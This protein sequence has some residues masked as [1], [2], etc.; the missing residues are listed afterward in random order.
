MKFQF[1][2][3]INDQDYFDYNLFWATRSYYGKKQ[4]RSVRV[5][6]MLLIAV[7]IIHSFLIS[8]FSKETVLGIIPLLILGLLSQIL[9]IKF[10]AFILKLHMKTLK[11][12]GKM[13]YSPES[14]I[15]FDDD[16][17][18]ETTPENKT[19]QKYSV[20]ERISVV[21]YKMIY[22]HVNTVLSYILPLSSFESNDQYDCF[23]EF[24]KT[25]CANIDLY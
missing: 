4:I 10:Y 1:H 19:E 13:G 23:M 15:E 11:K 6:L 20:I 25:K 18:C 14:Y 7:A 3:K 21:D 2:V 9:L 8:G 5:F 12:S 17:F 22:I 24:M 16:C